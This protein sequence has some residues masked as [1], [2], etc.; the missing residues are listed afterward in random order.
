MDARPHS[1]RVTRAIAASIVSMLACQWLAAARVSAG[2][3]GLM[4]TVTSPTSGSTV[5]GTITVSA[6][7]T[8]AGPLRIVAV[9]FQLDGGN[10]GAED[11]SAPFAT[12]WNTTTT[13][14]GSHTL[15]AVGRDQLGTRYTSQPVTVTVANGPPVTRID[16]TSSA[17]TYTGTWDLGN[18]DRSWSGGTAAVS[19]AAGARATLNFTGTAVKW[20]GFRGPQA[21]KAHVYV[22]GTRVATLDLYASSEAVQTVVY[23]VTGLT[24][25]SHTLA[26]EV[27]SPLSKNS[28]SSDYYVVV[29]AFDVTGSGAPPPAP[30][31][32]GDVFVSLEPGPVQWW[33]PDGTFRATLIS[34]VSGTG[35]GMGLD[36]AGN[37]YVTRWCMDPACGNGSGIEVFNSAGVSQ[38]R[39][40]GSLDCGPHAIV[41]DVA[42]N[43]Y[44]GQ[45]GCTGSILKISPGQP[46]TEFQV[47]TENEGS[48]WLD[49]APNGC[50]VFYTSW[51]PNIKRYNVCTRTQLANLNTGPLPGGGETHDVRVLPDG[52]AIVSNGELVVRLSAAGTVVRTYSVP[53]NTY[54]TGL[55]LVGDG[56]FWVGN[57]LTSNVYR[58]DLATGQVV[59]AFNT[60][61]PARTVV[62][63][64][65]KK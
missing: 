45:A 40:A 10:L 32:A 64:R 13:S 46:R 54:W 25:A 19:T 65:V 16:H 23:E 58:F 29:D 27:P 49:L 47:A 35:E 43:A 20:I 60:A 28:H 4:V 51:G 18:T 62:G 36:S 7:T 21:G 61:T 55:D 5:S 14:D 41:F 30:P 39:F 6:S 15:T 1:V 8:S 17:V 34:T 57:Y 52:G 12:P 26:V 53:E 48:F 44:V 24:S 9:Q 42:D 56:T 59:D 31:S 33:R 38:G 3:Q 37:L 50:T 63:V 22:D 2:G 11:T